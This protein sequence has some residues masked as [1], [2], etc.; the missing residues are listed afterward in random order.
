MSGLQIFGKFIINTDNLLYIKKCES[1]Y[2]IVFNN[3]KKIHIN[4]K[5]VET[6]KAIDVYYN[7]NYTV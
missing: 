2:M 1:R 5:N 4:D 3:G 7:R 6:Y